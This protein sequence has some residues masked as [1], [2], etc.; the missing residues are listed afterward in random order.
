MHTM[1]SEALPEGAETTPPRRH[2]VRRLVVTVLCVLL[3]AELT[4]RALESQ[5]PPAPVWDTDEYPMKIEQ[6][7]DLAELG[8]AGTVLL[9]SSVAD[10]SVDPAGLTPHD[11]RPAYN[12]GLIGATPFIVDVWARNIV[13]PTLRPSTVVIAISSRD[14]N[15]NGVGLE[16]SDARFLRAPATRELLG[17]QSFVDEVEWQ[18]SE[19]SALVRYRLL[20]R[21]PLEAVFGYDAPDR[22]MTELSPTGLETHLLA[23]QYQGSDVVLDFFRRE[24]LAGYELSTHQLDALE[25]VMTWLRGQ[26]IRVVLLD[27]PVTADYIALH[28]QTDDFSTY[29]AALAAIAGRTGAELWH[30]GTWEPEFFSDP[31]H[32]NGAG[33]DRL[34][35]E[36]NAYLTQ[37]AAVP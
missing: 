27:V 6:M 25:G 15:R 33:V 8:G 12:A 17:T 36:L 24:P 14:V 37:G 34:T 28:P 11:G 18:L 29:Q 3:L 26:G 21:R 5:L 32:L 2:R 7:D 30:P 4:V 13:L 16:P 9:G 35:A 22:N 20:L 31:L 19:W 10:V 23:D 1:E